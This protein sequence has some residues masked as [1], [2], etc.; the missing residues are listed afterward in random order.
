MGKARYREV[1]K[2]PPPTLHTKQERFL[3][4][5]LKPTF[6]EE[7]TQKWF[8]KVLRALQQ[9]LGP[10]VGRKLSGKKSL[11]KSKDFEEVYKRKKMMFSNSHI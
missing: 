1:S 8:Y 6:K 10:Q 7:A 4:N 5:V 2:K 9:C 11:R 3:R